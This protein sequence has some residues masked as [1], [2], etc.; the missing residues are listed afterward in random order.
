MTVTDVLPPGV[1]ATIAGAYRGVRKLGLE[2]AE[3]ELEEG[4][5][6]CSGNEG[7]PVAGATIV[8]CTNDPTGLPYLSGGNGT[9]TQPIEANEIIGDPVIAV[10]V[11]VP[12]QEGAVAEPNRVTVAGGGA[13][14]GASTSDPLTVSST[15]AKFG[16]NDTDAWFSNA[17]GTIDTRAGSHPYEATFIFDMN[18]QVEG[19]EFGTKPADGEE[20]NLAVNL[21]R[22][23]V[24]NPTAMPRCPRAL[25]YEHACPPNTQV[26]VIAINIGGQQFQN[27][28]PVF[29]LV[30]PEN[31][32]AEFGFDIAGVPTFVD[33]AVRSGSNYAL[34]TKVNNIAQKEV[35]GSVLTLWGEPEDKSH[36]AWHIGS[37]NGTGTPFLTLPT[38]CEGSSTDEFVWSTNEWEDPSVVAHTSDPVHDSHQDPVGF[39]GC[40]DLSF[41]PTITTAPDTSDADTPAGLTV[42]VKPSIGGLLSS[43]GVSAADLKNTT[44]ALPRGVAINPGQAAGLLACGPTEDGST[45]ETEKAEGR[46][47]NGPPSCPSASKVGTD[48]IQTPL[49]AKPVTGSVFLLRSEPPEVK[50]LVAASGEGVNL[51]L[52]GVVNLDEQTGQLVTTFTNTPALP[53]TLFRLSFSGGPQAALSTPTQCGTYGAAQGF[54]A[55]FT[56]WATPF[57]ADAFPNTAEFGI[58]AGTNGGPCPSSP[59]PFSPSMIAGSTTDQAAGYTSFSFLLQ[60][61][62]DQQRIGT[63]QFKTPEGLL[64][65]ISKVPLCPEPQASQ[66]TCSAASQ[67][68]HSVVA[69]G[70]GPYPLVVP[71]PGQPPAPIYLTG[72]YKGAPYGLSIVVPLVVGP[73]VLPTQVVRAR[74]D[75]DPHTARLTVTTDPL[76]TI[77]SGVPADLRTINAVIDR[78]EFMFNPTNC[79]PQAFTGIATST[80]GATAPLESH[81]Q[82]GSC[83]SLNF[84]PD[85]KVSTSGKTSRRTGASLDAKI[86]YPSTP[87]GFNQASSQSNIKS[88]K[89]DL[90]KQLPSRLT[91]LQK[92]CPVAT[93][94]ANPAGCPAASVV[95]HATAI[96]PVLPVQLTGPAYFVSH[97]GEEFPQLI[98][99]LQGYGVTIDLVGD[100][101]INSKTSITSSTFKQ[102]P[103]VPIT[104]FE[105]T[106]PQ[107]P[108][109]A[110]AA[111]TNLCKVKGG[112]KMPTS[113]T[114][115]DGAAIKQSTPINVTG[116]AKTK[117][118]KKGKG[119]HAGHKTKKK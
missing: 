103:D 101:F 31:E 11:T 93:F 33:S 30:P 8:T 62:D 5:W 68:G 86:V 42:E 51:K 66:G 38:S 105:L 13:L 52:V 24:G 47:D 54:S 97:A 37:V 27:A 91:T 12:S 28:T 74:I 60:R 59:L 56:S 117:T 45:T 77:I 29:N 76:P 113:F 107:G 108:F 6:D 70:P 49:L 111:N 67:I 80:E 58:T 78:P 15:P 110:L 69:A 14:S 92:A 72:G 20:R 115:Q 89:V 88:V 65:M 25:F 99:V 34:A 50:L 19:A 46:E 1:T 106:L 118:K 96:T 85:F 87:P 39:T 84:K 95:G 112:L 102:I 44:V 26:G 22:G 104:S 17:D 79:A 116:C 94:E 36:A 35:V 3:P 63:L 41:A 61:P 40:E 2:S 48:E 43:E 9:P 7:G 55:D 57:I 82:M 4:L 81:F 32:P 71:Q 109:S 16:F 73:F 53:F 100:T 64:G 114:A 83:R 21:P 18:S 119:K 98:I 23:F 90:P 10:G 75:V